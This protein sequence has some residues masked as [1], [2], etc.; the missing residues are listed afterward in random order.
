[1]RLEA[2]IPLTEVMKVRRSSFSQDHE[3]RLRE[4]LL[5]PVGQTLKRWAQSTTNNTKS[6]KS[7][8]WPGQTDEG[9]G[10]DW[11]GWKTHWAVYT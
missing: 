2:G 8:V 3:G 9:E 10:V 5:G 4:R 6:N 7:A 11:R 1:M